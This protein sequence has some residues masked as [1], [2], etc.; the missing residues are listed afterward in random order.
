MT[1][2]LSLFAD[3]LTPIAEWTIRLEPCA[4]FFDPTKH[5]KSCHKTAYPLAVR[6]DCLDQIRHFLCHSVC[7][8][9]CSRHEIFKTS[10]VIYP[11]GCSKS[12]S[13]R[14]LLAK[15]H[16]SLDQHE[17]AGR[18]VNFFL[19]SSLSVEMISCQGRETSAQW[20]GIKAVR[21]L[22]SFGSIS[23]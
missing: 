6:L 15:S 13:P 17:E 14:Y 11:F 18:A 10:S 5:Q 1:E 19:E 16:I 21:V 8:F 7:W 20:F 3:W 2:P 23:V 4:S 12:A 22:S 9:A